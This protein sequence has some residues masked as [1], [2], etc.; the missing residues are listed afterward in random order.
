MIVR[1]NS[2]NTGIAMNMENIHVIHQNSRELKMNEL[3]ITAMIVCHINEH[4]TIQQ[5][6]F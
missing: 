2:V 1:S 5:M 6:F 3:E 4:T